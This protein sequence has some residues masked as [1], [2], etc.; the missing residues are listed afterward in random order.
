[1][2]R[3]RVVEGAQQ[4]LILVPL[5]HPADVG[6]PEEIDLLVAGAVGRRERGGLEGE[7]LGH[8]ER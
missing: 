2:D 5:A 3:H 1:V 6:H 7:A 4:E 8:L